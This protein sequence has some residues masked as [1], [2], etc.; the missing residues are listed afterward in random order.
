MVNKALYGIVVVVEEQFYIKLENYFGVSID[1]FV[2]L[3]VKVTP[4]IVTTFF[5]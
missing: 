1:S 5:P 2:F 3:G 4:K